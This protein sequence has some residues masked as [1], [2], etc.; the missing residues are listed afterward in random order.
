M[1]RSDEGH[2]IEL[3]FIGPECSAEVSDMAFPLLREVYRDT[4][5]DVVESF[6]QR[7][8]TPEAVAEQIAAG[9]RYAFI[10]C[11]GECVGYLAYETDAEGMRLSKLYLLPESRG[12]GIGSFALG[13]V[14]DRAREAG[15]GSVHLE[16]NEISPRTIAFYEA[17]G[18]RTAGRMEYMRIVM[19]KVL[20]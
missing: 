12:K 8:Q 4:P 9:A 10:L 14:E 1:D 6:L 19:R 5:S 11:D 13:Y 20:D 18:Y 16:V 7:Y 15:L 17:H 3:D 2:H